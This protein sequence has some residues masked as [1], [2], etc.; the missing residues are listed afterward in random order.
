MSRKVVSLVPWWLPDSD[1][2]PAED[3]VLVRYTHGQKQIAFHVRGTEGANLGTL[4]MRCEK[5]ESEFSTIWVPTIALS[6]DID[7][8]DWREV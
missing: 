2:N 4:A 1:V 5:V 6:P 3:P 7:L 8:S